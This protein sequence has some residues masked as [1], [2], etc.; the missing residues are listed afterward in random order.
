QV[1]VRL[2]RGIKAHLLVLAACGLLLLAANHLLDLYDL[3]RSTRGPGGSSGAWYTDVHAQIPAQL[4]L[5]GAAT[6]AAVL[7]LANTRMAGFRPA[8]AGGVIWAV[9]LVAGAWIFPAALQ[10]ID[11]GPNELDRE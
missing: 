3:V 2:P 7:C 4:A 1:G 10:S 6:L 8:I 11:V 9:V 5:A